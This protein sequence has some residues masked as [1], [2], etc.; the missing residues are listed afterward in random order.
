MDIFNLKFYLFR[1]HYLI[2]SVLQ[3]CM[4]GIESV[5][6]VNKFVVN[7]FYCGEE[8]IRVP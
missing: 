5:S 1:S 8:V 3:R 7:K 2:I 6:E 4:F